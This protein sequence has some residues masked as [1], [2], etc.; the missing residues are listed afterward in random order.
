MIDRFEKFSSFI[1]D[2]SRHWHKIAAKEM[3]KYGLKGGHALYLT[4]LHH[5]PEGITAATLSELCSKDKADVSRAVS[6]LEGKGMVT[7]DDVNMNS[8]R[9]LIRLTDAGRTAS[10][11][12]SE[13]AKIAVELGSRGVPD[14]KR[15]I[16]YEVLSETSENLAKLS[17]DGLPAR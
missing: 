1:F 17:E 11:N 15:E 2:I 9:A 3:D 4:T 12:I 6:F 14:S 7:R 16:F 8:Y 10:E 5:F 13:R